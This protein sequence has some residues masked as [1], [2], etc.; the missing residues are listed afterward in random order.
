MNHSAAEKISRAGYN[1][2][3]SI[4]RSYQDAGSAS[5]NIARNLDVSL[6]SVAKHIGII[7]GKIQ[8][9]ELAANDIAETKRRLDALESSTLT[10]TKMLTEMYEMLYQLMQRKQDNHSNVVL[11]EETQMQ[12]NAIINDINMHD[13]LGSIHTEPEPVKI[14]EEVI[15]VEPIKEDI[16]NSSDLIEQ[17]S[18]VIQEE[19]KEGIKEEVK[20]EPIKEVIQET[21]KEEVK[22]EVKEEPIKEIIQE[23]P[24]EEPKEEPIKEEVK[25]EPIKEVVQESTQQ[26]STQKESTQEE[27]PKK[28]K[29]RA[30]K[31]DSILLTK[32]TVETLSK[33]NTDD[34]II[35]EMDTPAIVLD[36]T[37]QPK[38]KRKPTTRKKAT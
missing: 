4:P 24:K 13:L 12:P 38:P 21:P 16:L 5:T 28:K 32:D 3:L 31:E 15:N 37:P 2:T 34:T 14:V 35:I 19:P 36:P 22:E 11:V 8:N 1:E 27:K 17:S 26:E 25:E 6:R 10:H 20:E 23:T 30:K 33:P 29:G 9:V 18:E 7:H